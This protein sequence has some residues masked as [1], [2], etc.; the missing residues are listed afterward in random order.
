MVAKLPK[1]IEDELSRWRDKVL[2]RSDLH[3]RVQQAP[4]P[5]SMSLREDPDVPGCSNEWLKW[6]D[7][8][9]LHDEYTGLSMERGLIRSLSRLPNLGYKAQEK[10]LPWLI[11]QFPKKTKLIP[12]NTRLYYHPG[13]F[14]GWHTNSNMVG[15][16]CYITWAEE[17]GKSG[18]KHYNWRYNEII[19]RRDE[20][21]WQ[22]RIFKV[23]SMSNH[24]YW[25]SVWCDTNRVSLGFRAM[26]DGPHTFG[27]LPHPRD[28]ST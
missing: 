9:S 10:L 3:V 6:H 16:R 12:H 18:F 23:S 4:Y 15:W 7:K 8:R 28:A 13:D 25:H 17:G 11:E 24:F 26:G 27:I 14:L 1:D 2:S 19:D 22:L 20:E 5:F 21:G